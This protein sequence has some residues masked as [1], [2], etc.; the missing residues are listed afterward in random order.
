[1]P[2]EA[3]FIKRG[4]VR[5]IFDNRIGENP[6]K[7]EPHLQ[8]GVER[9]LSYDELPSSLRAPS[10]RVRMQTK[11]LW[12]D[13]RQLV[14]VNPDSVISTFK[15]QIMTSEGVD[16]IDTTSECLE[17][18]TFYV[19]EIVFS[20]P[21]SHRPALRPSLYR[22]HL[23][24]EHHKPQPPPHGEM[25][26]LRFFLDL[27]VD[28]FGPYR[29][30]Y[31]ALGGVYLAIGNLPLRLRQLIR[32]NFLFGFV[33]FGASFDDF[34]KPFKEEML[35]LQNGIEINING[36]PHWIVAGMSEIF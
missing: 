11:I 33:P 28:D 27:F 7:L 32:N 24:S 35:Q 22:H 5:Q 12:L 21:S 15:C 30:V 2:N 23:A 14:I 34:I 8:L 3:E 36:E 31:H 18:D 17:D 13:E 1:V 26:Y 4:R 19:Y 20:S 25:K 6:N 9:L 10:K 16:S 29:N